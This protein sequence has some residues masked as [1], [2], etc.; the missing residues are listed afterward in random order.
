MPTPMV[1][2]RELIKQLGG[3]VALSGCCGVVPSA[4][5]NWAAK[6]EVSAEHRITLWRMAVA[7]GIDWTPPGADGLVLAPKEVAA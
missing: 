2:V 4:V 3:P 6:N 1:T 7:A 5:T